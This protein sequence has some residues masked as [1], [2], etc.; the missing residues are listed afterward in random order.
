MEE[1]RQQLT[2][3]GVT[4]S[5]SRGG[6]STEQYGELFVKQG[7]GGAAADAALLRY[8]AEGLTRLAA[9]APSLT[10]PVPRLVGS[11]RDGNGFIVMDRLSLSGRCDLQKLGAGLADLHA[12][13]SAWEGH[14][15]AFGFPLDGCCGALEQPNN[16]SGRQMN[17]V[18]F[19]REHRLGHQLSCAPAKR[20][21]KLQEL[22]AQLSKRLDELFAML[23]V[24]DIQPSLLHGDLWSGNY[25]GSADG[26]PAIYD[27]ACYYGHYEA[28]HGINRTSMTTT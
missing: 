9:A 28:D 26:R 5:S 17:W 25:S 8:E 4:T 27:P 15:T 20:S 3:D 18:E 14:E 21:A 24:E 23:V 12:A 2:A 19:W 13:P 6:F 11:T 1:I 7:T 10:I 22:G 16:P